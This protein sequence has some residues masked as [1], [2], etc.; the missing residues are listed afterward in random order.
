MA[1][2]IADRELDIARQIGN[3]RLLLIV[4][5]T[6]QASDVLRE[7]QQALLRQTIIGA[8][9]TLSDTALEKEPI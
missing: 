8:Q 7:L 6:E 1:D 3:A 4:G 9:K 5:R 2:S